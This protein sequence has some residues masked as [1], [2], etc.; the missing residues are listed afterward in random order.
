LNPILAGLIT[1][2]A[3]GLLWLGLLRL[4]GLIG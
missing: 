4:T 2:L 3:S 1:A